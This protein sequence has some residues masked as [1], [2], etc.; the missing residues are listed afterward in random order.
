M[1]LNVV[2]VD[3]RGNLVSWWRKK[4]PRDGG[5]KDKEEK[6]RR[7]SGD[8]EATTMEEA[9]EGRAQEAMILSMRKFPDQE[10]SVLIRKNSPHD[11]DAG[12]GAGGGDI[13]SRH[14]RR[15][16]WGGKGEGLGSGWVVIHGN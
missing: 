5:G 9:E 14:E 11:E 8:G 2:S 1:R 16:T 3:G 4:R 6:E 7:G 13:G 15:R 12:G 10:T